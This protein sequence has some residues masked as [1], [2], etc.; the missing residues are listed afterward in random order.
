MSLFIARQPIFNQQL[1]VIAYE[2][3]FRDSA[4]G[5]NS[6]PADMDGD[7]ATAKLI[8]GLQ[9]SNG[10]EKLTDGKIAFINFT[11]SA[12]IQGKP[13][14]FKPQQVVVEVLETAKPTRSLLNAVKELYHMG[15]TVALDDYEEHPGWQ[16]FF[17]Y[18]K[19]IKFD[20][21]NGKPEQ[22]VRLKSQLEHHPHIKL[23]AEKVEQ[24]CQYKEMLSLNFNYF[25]GYFFSH[26]E[27][28]ESRTLS[29]S[30]TTITRLVALLMSDRSNLKDIQDLIESDPSLSYK[31]L[32][33]V[34]SPIFKRQQQITSIKQ[35]T[36]ALGF[37]ELRRFSSLLFANEMGKEKHVELNKLALSRAKFCELLAQEVNCSSA[38]GYSFLTGLL[39]LMDAMLDAELPVLIDQLPVDKTIKQAICSHKGQLG[40]YLKLA[41]YHE[42]PESY[43]A[44]SI[45]DD[46][47]ISN[48]RLNDLYLESLSWSAK[49]T[50]HA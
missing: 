20:I 13:K 29:V 11:H 2:L 8:S 23:L 33:Y 16:H 41:K 44:E 10:L 49:Q 19:M 18:I 4:T 42:S 34:Q 32:R 48:H 40:R 9:L 37:K 26:P 17:A 24:H 25:Q 14:L 36:I 5:S 39:S 27:V 28:I 21:L 1:S 45:V 15:Y 46:L 30:Q 38:T 47:N 3:L 31:L 50:L 43:D 22:L 6:F 12:I 7:E 35:A